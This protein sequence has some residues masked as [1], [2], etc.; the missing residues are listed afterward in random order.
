MWIYKISE[1]NIKGDGNVKQQTEEPSAL[2]NADWRNDPW[3][4]VF[5]S[6][7]KLDSGQ[8]KVELHNGRGTQVVKEPHNNRH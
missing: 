6:H 4:T 8:T 7:W 2:S 5:L 1:M 3:R